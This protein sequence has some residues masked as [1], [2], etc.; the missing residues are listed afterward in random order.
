MDGYDPA[1]LLQSLWQKHLRAARERSNREMSEQL[2]KSGGM[3]DPWA[4]RRRNLEAVARASLSEFENRAPRGSSTYAFL[5]DPQ[6][7]ELISGWSAA[8][9]QRVVSRSVTGVGPRE[10]RETEA[11]GGEL[12]T[13]LRKFA[14]AELRVVAASLPQVEARQARQLDQKFGILDGPQMLREDLKAARSLLGTAVVYL[15]LDHFKQLNTRFTETLVDKTVLP[16]FQRL[17]VAASKGHGHAYAEGG[18]EVTILLENFTG[19]MAASF[20]S[21]LAQHVRAARFDI[22][23]ETVS[24]TISAGV[25]AGTES[26]PERANLAKRHA[27][28]SGRDCVSVWSAGGCV[29]LQ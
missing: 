2:G 9:I 6:T 17:I 20:A 21:A 5:R 8:E 19:T 3:E 15:D 4:V 28:E 16:Q 22:A 27:K 18:D 10:A 25:A 13:H 11:R 26:L 29:K 7:L 14:A 24:L 1:A 23:G 12:A